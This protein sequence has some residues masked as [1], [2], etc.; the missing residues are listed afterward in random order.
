MKLRSTL[1]SRLRRS[2]HGDEN[3]LRVIDAFLNAAAETQPLGGDIAVNQFF[4][5]GLV[6]RHLAGAEATSILRASLSTQITLWPTSAKQA[7]VTR[8]T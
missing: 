5:A 8:P 6:D 1:P 3:D 4:Q 7:P 2:R